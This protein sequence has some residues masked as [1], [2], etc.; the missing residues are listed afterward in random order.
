MF[1]RSRVVLIRIRGNPWERHALEALKASAT[2]GKEMGGSTAPRDPGCLRRQRVY[3]GQQALCAT[4]EPRPIRTHAVR[5]T[6]IRPR[7]RG[8]PNEK[9]KV[10]NDV[11]RK[12]SDISL[13]P[14]FAISPF[15]RGLFNRRHQ[16][17]GQHAPLGGG[18]VRWLCAG[19]CFLDG[20][21]A[22]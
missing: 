14:R 15:F 22:S 11:C 8:P 18:A 20:G 21:A 2:G 12:C 10:R 3:V 16:G 13:F 7:D 17:R 5:T 4:C 1:F 6:A 19:A 9:R